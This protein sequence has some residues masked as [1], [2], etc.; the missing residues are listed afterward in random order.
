MKTNIQSLNPNLDRLN[1]KLLLQRI[2]A[3]FV[4]EI[5]S[6]NI[7]DIL[8]ELRNLAA[9]PLVVPDDGCS[10]TQP[11]ERLIKKLTKVSEIVFSPDRREQYVRAQEKSSALIGEGKTKE[12]FGILSLKLLTFHLLIATIAGMLHIGQ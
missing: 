5:D 7:S 11:V 6:N 10:H 3:D 2:N 8:K 12:I 1:Q 4:T 9:S